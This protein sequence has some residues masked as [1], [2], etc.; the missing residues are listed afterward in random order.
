MA[1]YDRCTQATIKEIGL[2][3]GRE[4]LHTVFFGGGTPSIIG[5]DRLVSI[6]N[7]LNQHFG[8]VPEAEITVEVNP[9]TVNI[10]QLSMLRSA[11]F[12]RI[13]IGVQCFDDAMLRLLGRRHNA[14]QAK[15]TMVIARDA[16]FSNVSIDLMSALPSQT[17]DHHINQL[18][19]ACELSPEHISCYSLTLEANTRLAQMVADGTVSLPDDTVQ[20]EMMLVTNQVLQHRGYHQYEVSNYCQTGYECQHNMVYWQALPYWGFGPAA[21]STVD[22]IRYSREPSPTRYAQLVE[23]SLSPVIDEERLTQEQQRFEF[24]MLALRTTA[25]FD[26][27]QLYRRY[28]PWSGL[29]QICERLIST[30]HLIRNGQRYHL[31]SHGMLVANDV[32]LEFLP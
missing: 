3:S 2:C 24:L 23:A 18:Q 5:A 32:I 30:G 22:G 27:Q 26:I 19:Q 25:G 15:Q 14:D 4:P 17:V 16:G 21:V 10:K 1:D 9:A 6:L 20:A 29:P 7:E 13:S 28:G 31:S 12:N 11:G 8:I